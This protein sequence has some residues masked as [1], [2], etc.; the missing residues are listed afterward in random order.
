[1]KEIVNAVGSLQ[2]FADGYKQFG[3]TRGVDK[4]KGPG[5]YYREWAPNARE[6]SLIGQ[7]NKWDINAN[8]LKRDEFGWFETF[9]PDVNGQS[10]IPHGSLIKVTMVTNQGARI[11]R[12]PAWIKRS[13]QEID[14]DTAK[15]KDVFTGMYW[16]PAKQYKWENVAH[17]TM[18]DPSKNEHGLKIYESHVGM[19]SVEEKVNTY[20]EFADDVLPRIKNNGYNTV[21]LMAVM[22]HAYYG[23]FGYHVTSFFAPSSRFGTPEDLK[24]LVDKAHGMGLRVI[25]DL[26]HSYIYIYII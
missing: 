7:F 15:P 21:Q 19:S 24:Y 8:P 2:Q 11:Y 6:M 22:E 5:I 25:M 23:S 13:I 20:R 12:I 4:E 17:L 16:C 3:F 10:A 9:L 1:M 18:P 14:P 26:I